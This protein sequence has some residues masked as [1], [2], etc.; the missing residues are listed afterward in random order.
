MDCQLVTLLRLRRHFWELASKSFLF[1]VTRVENVPRNYKRT[2]CNSRIRALCQLCHGPQIVFFSGINIG[3]TFNDTIPSRDWLDFT[4]QIICTGRQSIFN[5]HKSCKYK[6]G[7]II[8]SN[9]FHVKRNPSCSSSYW[10][11]SYI[12]SIRFFKLITNKKFFS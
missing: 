10:Y 5:I 2:G 1:F 11:V 12:C 8:L 9:Y 3:R 4:N 7:N 6:N